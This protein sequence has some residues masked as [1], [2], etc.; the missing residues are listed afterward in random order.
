MW[1]MIKEVIEDKYL[2]KDIK[3]NNKM[4]T[5]IAKVNFQMVLDHNSN[6]LKGGK[7]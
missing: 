2:F 7:K 3:T 4:V 5:K 1:V 6:T